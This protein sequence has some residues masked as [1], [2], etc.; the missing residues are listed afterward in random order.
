VN[1]SKPTNKIGPRHVSAQLTRALVGRAALEELSS[2]TPSAAFSIDAVAKRACVAR[3]T[4]FNCYANRSMLLH[5][6][7]DEMAHSADLLDVTALMNEP[8]IRQAFVRY[9]DCF[10]QFYTQYALPL[11]R[12][13]A[14]AA[15]DA[16]LGALMQARDDERTAGL[17]WLVQ[18]LV[19]ASPLDAPTAQVQAVVAHLKAMLCL[20]VFESLGRF[21]CAETSNTTP[22]QEL[23]AMVD[24]VLAQF[25]KNTAN[26]SVIWS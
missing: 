17:A 1:P 26:V 5:A 12:L 14:Y 11:R 23:W 8:D 9:V 15:L 22:S 10:A 25:I 3:M 20:E 7:C 4:V 6:V 19:G 2:A 13:R 21:A 18:R 16:E 24:A